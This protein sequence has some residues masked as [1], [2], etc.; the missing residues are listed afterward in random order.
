MTTN[1]NEVKYYFKEYIFD[2]LLP[3][4]VKSDDFMAL[5]YNENTPLPTYEGYKPLVVEE[6]NKESL[7]R[8]KDR[9]DVVIIVIDNKLGFEKVMEGQK[10]S[11]DSQGRPVSWME[12]NYWI[13]APYKHDHTRSKEDSFG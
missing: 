10:K 8:L 6:L 7:D 2:T 11:Y 12:S 9:D 3:T 1:K 13:I 4:I 5:R